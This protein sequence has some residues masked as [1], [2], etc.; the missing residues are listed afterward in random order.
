MRSSSRIAALA[1]FA[2]FFG[3]PR[4]RNLGDARQHLI[5]NVVALVLAII[6][7]WPHWDTTGAGIKPWGPV[8]S[9]LVVLILLFTGWRV[10]KWC[11]A[12]T[13]EQF[14]EDARALYQSRVSSQAAV[15]A[16]RNAANRPK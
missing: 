11:S 4:I 12:I 10:V 9:I 14:Q 5:G 16:T 13:S 2:D 15:I 8:L 6:N 1:G 7:L 3:N